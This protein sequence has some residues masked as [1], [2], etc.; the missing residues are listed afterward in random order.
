MLVALVTGSQMAK[1]DPESHLLI[2]ELKRV[3]IEASL[4]PW[5]TECD[6]SQFDLVLIRTPWDYFLQ[7][8][9]FLLW[10]QR[11]EKATTLLN[12]SK[13]IS[14]NS[15]KKYLR[16]LAAKGIPTV[17][18]RWLRKGEASAGVMS[19]IEWSRVV[20][21]PAVS[22]GAIGARLGDSQ[23]QLMQEHLDT[24][25][26][27]GDVM[28]QPYLNSIETNGEISLVYFGGK[29]SHAI[30]KRPRQGDYRVQDSYGGVN[31]LYYPEDEVKNLANK[32]LKATPDPAFYARVDLIKDQESWLLMELEL[33]EPELFFP[34]SEDS[35]RQ[36]AELIVNKIVDWPK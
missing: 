35:A 29:Y 8:N 22:I 11:T 34:L 33:I 21:K 26:L 27:E 36:F 9:D 7:L 4:I 31:T 1:G 10:A 23:D 6:W 16:E 12:S 32:I 24:L 5:Q 30:C 3:G 14:W 20:I 19:E 18:T 13:L 25:S 2:D 28:I 15:H 17:P